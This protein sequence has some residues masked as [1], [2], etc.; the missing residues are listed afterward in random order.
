MASGDSTMTDKAGSGE[1]KVRESLRNPGSSEHRPKH[2]DDA[3][4]SSIPEGR[5][6]SRSSGKMF[7]G[8]TRG[9]GGQGGQWTTTGGMWQRCRSGVEGL[10]LSTGCLEGAEHR[11]PARGHSNRTVRG[12]T[13]QTSNAGSRADKQLGPMTRSEGKAKRTGF[14]CAV[15][16][17]RDAPGIREQLS[18]HPARSR[19]S[20]CNGAFLPS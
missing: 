8:R 2:K 7:S 6:K 15:R 12:K 10:G 9:A 3:R 17:N 16:V 1:S 19:C 20:A 5:T 18:Q 13:A 11:G 4:G 14:R